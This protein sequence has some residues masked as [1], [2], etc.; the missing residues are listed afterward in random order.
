MQDTQAMTSTDLLM[1]LLAAVILLLFFCMGYTIVGCRRRRIS[2]E[3]KC[4]ESEYLRR[5]WDLRSRELLLAYARGSPNM[6]LSNMT[7]VTDADSLQ[8]L[9]TLRSSSLAS[10]FA[11]NALLDWKEL[12]TLDLIGRGGFGNVYRG[13][14]RGT[15]VAVKEVFYGDAT[16]DTLLENFVR[17]A[18]IMSRL[19]HPN[20]VLYI[21]LSVLQNRT[22]SLVTELMEQGNLFHKLHGKV[23]DEDGNEDYLTEMNMERRLRCALN[24]IRGLN[25]LHRCSPPIV[26]KDFKSLNLLVAADWTVKVADFGLS[27]IKLNSHISSN[28]GGTPEWSAPEVLR[29]ERHGLP[30]DIYSFG[31][32]LWEIVTRKVPYEGLRGIQISYLVAS[33]GERLPRAN[34]GDKCK[35]GDQLLDQMNE[36]IMDCTDHEPTARPTA[37][38]VLARLENMKSLSELKNEVVET[39]VGRLVE[40]E[41]RPVLVEG[42]NFRHRVHTAK[43]T[44]T[45]EETNGKDFMQPAQKSVRRDGEVVKM[46]GRARRGLAPLKLSLT[47]LT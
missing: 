46:N 42:N 8:S 17:E 13:V 31:V 21:G 18:G 37:E 39:R 27:S 10:G 41:R 24:A 9:N 26:H 3:A 45:S 4:E 7:S 28:F 43:D 47:K 2:A 12:T 33:R 6:S 5:E 23:S 19:R 15:P 16:Q 1:R 14:W 25:Y 30:C 35:I 38:E 32:V 20:I 29:N 34:P 11:S 40:S 22:I 44:S 36:L